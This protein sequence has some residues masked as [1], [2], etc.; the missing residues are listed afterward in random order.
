[1][2]K[3]DLMHKYI[4]FWLRMFRCALTGSTHYFLWL[5]LLGVLSLLGLYS[6]G[7][8]FTQGFTV[9]H[10]SDQVSWGAYIANFTFL[11]GVAAAAVL[12]VVPSYLYKDKD[13]KKVVLLGEILAFVA[14]IMCLLFIVV[15]LGR[16]DRFLHILPYLGKLN[17]P[18]S[19]LAWDVIVVNGYL[20][21]NNFIPGYLLYMK[22]LGKEP[23]AKY[24]LPFV[25]ISIVWAVSPHGHSFFI[26]RTW[27]EALLEYS[28]P[29]SSI[30]CE[31]FR[32][33]PGPVD[34]DFPGKSPL[35][36]NE[37]PG[38]SLRLSKKD[39]DL[40]HAHQPFPSGL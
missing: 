5:G 7:A 31:R 22:Y 37:N 29:G 4:V 10:L 35:H 12:L 17:F 24:Y 23:N 20:F 8:Q 34:V 16:P 9:T 18:Q 11:V 15:D 27:R 25:F 26:Q 33:W 32:G 38:G 6:Y 30:Y 19:I 1:M 3:G 28:H 2:L 13:V 14:L 39:H 36:Q 21:L 40:H